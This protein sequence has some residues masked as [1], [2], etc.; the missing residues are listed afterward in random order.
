MPKKHKTV[1]D[2]VNAAEVERAVK[3]HTRKK[4]DPTVN[5]AGVSENPEPFPAPAEPTQPVHIR[6]G[7][8]SAVE[9]TV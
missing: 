7:T 8:D 3:K 4:A 9:F 6:I 2:Q 5:G 1:T